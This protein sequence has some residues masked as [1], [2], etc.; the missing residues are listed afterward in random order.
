[1]IV[2]KQRAEVDNLTYMSATGATRRS[3]DERNY[4]YGKPAKLTRL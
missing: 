2:K 4:F 3:M 1:M